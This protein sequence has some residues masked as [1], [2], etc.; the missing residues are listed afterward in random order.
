MPLPPGR[1]P[2]R[3]EH[4]WPSVPLERHFDLDHVSYHT[5]LRFP[6]VPIPHGAKIISARLAWWPTNE[7][8][9]SSALMLEVRAEKAANSAPFYLDSYDSGRPDQRP[10]T[11]AGYDHWV[12]RCNA[13]CSDD[14]SSPKWEYDCA[15]RKL[16]CWN[17]EVRYECQKDLAP[18]VQEVVDM[19]G[20]QAGNA[21]LLT[22]AATDQDGPKY[23]GS[24]TITGYDPERGLDYRP[25]LTIT[26]EGM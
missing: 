1:L 26:W 20:W 6:H 21:V 18:I 24:R 14:I 25:S 17:R 19:E 7:V 10:A 3:M 22:N 11:T 2:R 23:K 15:Q 5:A 16:D 12:V 9:S 8:D 4:L 13:D